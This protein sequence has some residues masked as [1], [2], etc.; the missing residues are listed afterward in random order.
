MTV[1]SDN[2][3]QGDAGD[4][5]VGNGMGTDETGSEIES[6]RPTVAEKCCGTEMTMNYMQCM[7]AELQTLRNE[8]LELKQRLSN[9]NKK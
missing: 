2:P 1:S 5:E 9:K 8:N 7:E 6:T 4:G 3:E